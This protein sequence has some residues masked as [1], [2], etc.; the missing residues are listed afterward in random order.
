[1]PKYKRRRLESQ[2]EGHPSA[3]ASGAGVTSGGSPILEGGKQGTLALKLGPT[4][5]A[6]FSHLAQPAAPELSPQQSAV[7]E[8]INQGISIFFTGCAGTGKS[9][10]LRHAIEA[11]RAKHSGFNEVAVC[12][13]TGIAAVNIGGVTLHSWACVG[14]GDGSQSDLLQNV[15][16]HA[17][18]KNWL[19]A[20][21]LV[22]D[23][24][25]MLDARLLDALEYIARKMRNDE[26]IF[27]GLQ[28]V[29]C[30]DFFQ[31]PPVELERGAKFCFQAACWPQL[32]PRGSVFVLSRVFR[33]RDETFLQILEEVRR[34]VVSPQA[35]STLRATSAQSFDEGAEPTR[36]FPHNASADSFNKQKL[37]ALDGPEMSFD[38]VD[39]GRQPYLRDLQKHC[40]APAQLVLKPGT[41]V[42]LLKNIGVELGLANGARGVVQSFE[43]DKYGEL[44]PVVKMFVAE[45]AAKARGTL[46]WQFRP[47]KWS[48]EQNG[49]E[50]A[51]REQ[52]P[53][54]LS[55]AISIHKSQGLTIDMLET[56][57]GVVWE[58]G[59]AYVALSRGTSLQRMRVLNFR[60]ELVKT[61]PAVKQFGLDLEQC[62]Q[63]QYQKSGSGISA[64][65]PETAVAASEQLDTSDEEL[66]NVSLPVF[67]Q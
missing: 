42:M 8:R 41:Q 28:L 33:Q 26:R 34:G 45:T 15:R 54:M 57:L 19:T 13:S 66:L 58:A 49:K 25:S 43:P 59:Q 17:R 7:L 3:S 31:L 55:W 14:L 20:K 39:S 23:E 24:L 27:G 52:I 44:L 62:A 38:A 37:A 9:F 11:L 51:S 21:A 16:T 46:T 64:K 22:I 56:D 35:C 10:L 40:R 6:R 67:A 29:L 48:V 63:E 47:E 60:P 65:A 4:L 18:R 61:H 12:A 32:V 53:L 2:S 50:L 5:A 30:G 36:L 1:M